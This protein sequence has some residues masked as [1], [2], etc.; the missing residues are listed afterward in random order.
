MA[1]Y[2][3]KF[4]GSSVAD[5]AKVYAAA[6]KLAALQRQGHQ[7]VGVLSAQGKETDR[8]LALAR[9]VDP[10]CSGREVDALLSTGETCSISLCGLALKRLG[11]PALGLTG[12]Q[13]GLQT[14]STHGGA[15]VL[16]LS[17]DRIAQELSR[18]KIVLGA[19]FQ[20]ID[21]LGDITTLGRGGSDT[22]AVAL[23]AF[24]KADRCLIYTDVDGVYDKDPRLHAD[25]VK[26]DVISYDRMLT[27]ARSGAKVLHDRCV[28]LAKQHRVIIEVL[29][30]YRDLPGTLV[31]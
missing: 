25:A 19:G 28:E 30:S 10:D 17:N 20:G 11:I 24:L 26:Y 23:A 3:L 31:C 8:L 1:R 21:A 29:S 22:T 16:G 5:T 12:W 27:L 15:R 4:G 18:G 2:V 14:E 6:R 7:V 13:A 9:E